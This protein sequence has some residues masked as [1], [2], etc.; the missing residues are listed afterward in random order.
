MLK[1][2]SVRNPTRDVA[3]LAV[4][5]AAVWATI[6]L[7]R[8]VTKAVRER[9]GKEAFL[10]AT[11]LVVAISVAWLWRRLQTAPVRARFWI[12]GCGAALAA[13]AFALRA[14]PVETLHLI[15]YAG[16]GVLAFRALSHRAADPT[17]YG[18]AMLL[19]AG[20][21]IIDE[22]IQW[23]TPERVWDL[24]D[25][26]INAIAVS[27]ALVPI[28][29]GLRPD[30]VAPR[31]RADGWRLLF[32][33][34]AFSSLLLLLSLAATPPRLNA[35]GHNVPGL[36]FLLDHPDVMLEYGHR[37]S[38]GDDVRFS[39]RFDA[40][41]LAKSDDARASEAG[42]ILAEWRGQERYADFLALYTVT[43][44][45]FLHEL[46]VHLFRRDRYRETAEWHTDDPA[47]RRRDL[48]V[49]LREQQILEAAFPRTLAASGLDLAPSARAALAADV[50]AIS[51]PYAS[52]VSGHLITERSEAGV[53]ALPCLAFIG[54]L[55][56]W[57][58]LRRGTRPTPGA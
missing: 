49:A 42:A 8:T 34:G 58:A 5:V 16:I 47:W 30:W 14:D 40:E 35:I 29:F 33:V 22:G 51:E 25:I 20:A 50:G 39:S 48:V 46:R 11:L 6:P 17:L 43:R 21:G 24:R 19:G 44:D 52:P 2:P 7:A 1:A 26:G 32:Q 31:P 57:N 36:A 38:A 45:P 9:F 4:A 10:W 41:S 3:A 15:E 13:Y 18:S 37:L 12:L 55:T 27:A 23:L 53:L 56:G 54:C 28:A